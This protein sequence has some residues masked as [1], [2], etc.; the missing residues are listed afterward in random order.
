M[1]EA[2]QKGDRGRLACPVRSEECKRLTARNL[3]V[4]TV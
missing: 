1:E 4:E 2:E 3:E